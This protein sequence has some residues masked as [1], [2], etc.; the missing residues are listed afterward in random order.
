MKMLERFKN[1]LLPHRSLVVVHLTCP[2]DNFI[3]LH[4]IYCNKLASFTVSD[5]HEKHCLWRHVAEQLTPRTPDLE[6]RGS[7]RP[8]LP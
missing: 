6:V 3:Q 5:L 2:T 7:S 4:G 8:L 1:Y